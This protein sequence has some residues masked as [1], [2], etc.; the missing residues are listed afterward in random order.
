MG[1]TRCSRSGIDRS[2]PA[3][4]REAY[5]PSSALRGRGAGWVAGESD[6]P[7]EVDR[8]ADAENL[9]NEQPRLIGVP[10]AAARSLDRRHAEVV[11]DEADDGPLPRALIGRTTE[12][13][14]HRDGRKSDRRPLDE[15]PQAAH[16]LSWANRASASDPRRRDRPTKAWACARSR[17][18]RRGSAIPG[19]RPLRAAP[20]TTPCRSPSAGCAAPPR[21]PREPRTDPG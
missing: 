14:N 16:Q 5:R 18:R 9:R 21:P 20:P 17:A 8:P 2:V 13:L 12:L 7:R 3:V 11:R 4:R 1:V 19:P 10:P 6:Q 15:L